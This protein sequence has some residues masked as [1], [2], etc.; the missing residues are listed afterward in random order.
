MDSDHGTV[1]ICIGEERLVRIQSEGSVRL[2]LFWPIVGTHSNGKHEEARDMMDGTWMLGYNFVANFLLVPL[3][4]RMECQAPFDWR[5]T[6]CKFFQC[7]LIPENGE[8]EFAIEE[9][10]G[11][12]PARREIYPAYEAC[13]RKVQGEFET[14]LQPVVPEIKDPEL[15]GGVPLPGPQAGLG[16]ADEYVRPSG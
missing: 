3:K 4:G 10:P 6:F 2:R 9:F 15:S 1:R 5:G 7:D 11:F 13:V 8:I 12:T 14:F 16:A